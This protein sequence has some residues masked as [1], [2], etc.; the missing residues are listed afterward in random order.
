M[1]ITPVLF[2]LRTCPQLLFQGVSPVC[3]SCSQRIAL[4]ICALNSGSLYG[5][6][7][8][9]VWAGGSPLSLFPLP[10]CQS[11]LSVV[12][13]NYCLLPGTIQYKILGGHFD[14]YSIVVRK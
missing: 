5:F 12:A 7:M 3:C 6:P 11:L 4:W 14:L 10:D 2:S 8:G 9:L 1:T 13:H